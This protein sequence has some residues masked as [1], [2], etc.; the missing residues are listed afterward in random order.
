MHRRFTVISSLIA[1]PILFLGLWTF[2][3]CENIRPIWPYIDTRFADGFRRENWNAL[4]SG[5]SR[6][7]VYRLLGAYPLY[8]QFCVERPYDV[9]YSG[10]K[11][12]WWYCDIYSTD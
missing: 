3:G 4:R 11:V 6:D 10:Q 7:E 12:N 9:I 1:L 8:D 5:M 2:V